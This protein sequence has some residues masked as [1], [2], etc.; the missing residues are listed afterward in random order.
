MSS[1]VIAIV[2]L[3]ALLANGIA[4]AS[5]ERIFEPFEQEDG[6]AT[7]HYEGIGLGLSIGQE[8]VHRHGG[9]IRVVAEVSVGTTFTARLPTAWA[10]EDGPSACEEDEAAP[11]RTT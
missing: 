5:L 6:S 7:R 2:L 9:R 10:G 8:M 1:V 4:R 11:T 3:R